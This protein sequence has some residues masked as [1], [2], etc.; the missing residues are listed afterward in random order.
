MSW[1]PERADSATSARRR[2]HVVESFAPPAL[3]DSGGDHR[4]ESMPA[5][6]AWASRSSNI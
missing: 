6:R 3:V 4:P 5:A 2:H 1:S